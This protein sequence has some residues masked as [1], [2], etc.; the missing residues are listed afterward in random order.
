MG[1][2]HVLPGDRTRVQSLDTP[3]GHPKRHSLGVLTD[4]FRKPRR[5]SDS[6]KSS[7]IERY[8]SAV[9]P[10]TDSSWLSDPI[11]GGE[12]ERAATIPIIKPPNRKWSV[13]AH[14]SSM[15]PLPIVS[16]F[17]ATTGIDNQGNKRIN[18][19][20]VI[21]T[22]GKGSYGK[23]KLCRNV[24]TKELRAIKVI[25]K[26]NLKPMK[27][28]HGPRSR[29]ACEPV[30]EVDAVKQELAILKKLN[31]P[32]IVR[33]F[34]VIDDPQED[35]IYLV[36]EYVERGEM[37]SLTISN[38]EITGDSMEEVVAK[39]YFR[40]LLSALEYLHCNKVLHRDIK[41]ANC[42]ITRDGDL[43]LSDFGVSKFIHRKKNNE[44][45]YDITLMDSS[46]TPAFTPPEAC[47]KGGFSGRPADIWTAGVTLYLMVFGITPFNGQG[48]GP[49]MIFSLYRSIQ[50]DDLQIPME[51]E[52]SS[53]LKNLLCR[54]LNK[55]PEKRIT[56]NELL[57]HPWVVDDDFDE[58]SDDLC[59]TSRSS[60]SMSSRQ[61]RE[62]RMTH[63]SNIVTVTSH[64][65]DDAI[66]PIRESPRYTDYDLPPPSIHFRGL[67]II[68]EEPTLT[69]PVKSQ[70][71]WSL[72]A[73]RVYT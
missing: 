60:S 54:L 33:L 2:K 35:K 40:Q 57:E 38:G 5:H 15:P 21:R 61:F 42:L 13:R 3:A 68:R 19:Y 39:G 59:L 56:L 51:P 67:P 49:A 22:L 6:H 29:Q 20:I 52:I 43:K 71:R 55:D 64:D 47:R 65:V 12:P 18:Q 4:F 48:T 46:G 25:T 58:E 23:V 62:A 9:T 17:K 28:F 69:F 14:S 50:E 72:A 10:T 37:M 11:E 8:K 53:N 44:S 26:S 27:K 16:T 24:E 63:N 31:H 32:N 34:E 45:N 41:P 66:L 70:R 36:F 1:A 30:D 7:R 73:Q